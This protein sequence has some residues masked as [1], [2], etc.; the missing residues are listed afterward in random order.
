MTDQEKKAV[1]TSLIKGSAATSI[2]TVISMFF[3]FFSIMLLTRHLSLDDFG[4]YILILA[5]VNFFNIITGLGLNTTIVKMIAS[6]DSDE[7]KGVLNATL[8][9]RFAALFL[10]SLLFVISGNHG[11]RL[12]SEQLL[13][14]L[15]YFPLLV[16]TGSFRDLF[17]SIYQAINSFQKYAIIQVSSA[18]IRIVLIYSFYYYQILTLHNLIYIE[19]GISTF[20]VIIQLIMLNWNA[21][22]LQ[23]PIKNT[24]K[25]LLSFGLPLYSNS[26]F[27]FVI[28]RINVFLLGIYLLPESIALFDISDKIPQAFQKIYSSF[29]IVYFPNFSKVY[30]NNDKGHARHILENTLLITM[31]ILTGG[32]L[33]TLLFGKDILVTIFSESYHTAAFSFALLMLA[34]IFKAISNVMGY[35]LVGAGHP[36]IPVK[37]NFISCSI[38]ILLSLLL[39]PRL[40]FIGASYSYLT[41]NIIAT[42]IYGIFVTRKL[43]SFRK[44]TIY[45][46]LVIGS[47]PYLFYLLIKLESLYIRIA[48]L[49]SYILLSFLFIKELKEMTQMIRNYIVKKRQAV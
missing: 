26:I 39:I 16:I 2:G 4:I 30:N 32:L 22:N 17:Y 44:I 33:V 1:K 49:F 34:F 42:F 14:F 28:Q 18:I 27:N 48:V 5:I 40:G 31:V 3:H 25:N 10:F 15:L 36:S 13:P 38:G 12:I 47:M 23:S 21:L 7:A 43:F 37:T 45:K 19:L 24:Y 29:I 46:P 41:M 8:K 35:S 6:H 11:L 9:I 20:T